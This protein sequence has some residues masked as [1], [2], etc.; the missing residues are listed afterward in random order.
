MRYLTVEE[1]L[2]LHAHVLEQ[3]GGMSGL[4]DCGLLESAIAQPQMTFAGTDLFP[5]VVDKAAA[6]G[7]FL[8]CNHPFADGNKR[9][10][11]LAMEML[12]YL[13]GFEIEAPVD[14]QEKIIL[15]V[16]A[17]ELRREAFADWL[18]AHTRPKC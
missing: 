3:S 6:L 16:A 18:R 1:V 15:Q 17:G 5:E 4:R 7:F 12:L 14:K 8:I 10:G 13:N 9:V 2:A 11:H